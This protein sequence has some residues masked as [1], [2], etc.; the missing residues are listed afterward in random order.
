MTNLVLINRGHL[1]FRRWLSLIS[2]V[3]NT[4]LVVTRFPISWFP[5]KIL[6]LVLSMPYL[7]TMI[8]IGSAFGR[9]RARIKTFK[10][11]D[12][13]LGFFT[14]ES[15]PSEARDQTGGTFAF[16]KLVHEDPSATKKKLYN[17]Y[18]LTCFTS[19]FCGTPI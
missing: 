7:F 2:N 18:F 5:I 9:R 14:S 3:M 16:I 15:R 10:H 17:V 12:M 1:G 19:L 13:T 11:H 6:A 4:W 8:P